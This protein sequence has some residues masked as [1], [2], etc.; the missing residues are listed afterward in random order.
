MY[1]LHTHTHIPIVFIY[2]PDCMFLFLFLLTE[3]GKKDPCNN[4]EIFAENVIATLS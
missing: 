4:R 3:E 2:S 1:I